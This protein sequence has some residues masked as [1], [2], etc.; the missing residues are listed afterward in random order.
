MLSANMN[1]V[2]IFSSRS[3]ALLVGAWILLVLGCDRKSAAT[4]ESVPNRGADVSTKEAVVPAAARGQAASLRAV[5]DFSQSN[6][7]SLLLAEEDQE[8]G[9]KHN[10]K[11][12]DGLTT[13]VK[14]A[15]VPCR[16]LNQKERGRA[17]AFLYFALDPSFK[18]GD[19]RNVKIE[20]EYFDVVFDDPP[21]SISLQY[22][23][24]SVPKTTSAAYR[25]VN[26]SVLLRGANEWR[27]ATFRVRGATF[28]NS[29]NGSSDFRICARPPELYVRRVTVTRETNQD[30]TIQFPSP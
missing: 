6:S 10:H 2:F 20:V 28:A 16:Y 5:K 3:V 25:R 11:E 15:D 12:K 14:V 21:T 26:Q 13:I 8:S 24:T 22:D 27:T 23:A 7:V 19:A 1:R 29:Q 30:P 18:A 17:E 9:L 4:G